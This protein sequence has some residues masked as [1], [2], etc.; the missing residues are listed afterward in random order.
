ML[1]SR[2]EK[3]VKKAL[4]AIVKAQEAVA[5]GMPVK[6]PI[7]KLSKDYELN[8]EDLADRPPRG[9]LNSSE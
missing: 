1:R 6:K 8:L 4:V 2:A 7:D 3:Q 9:D 5:S